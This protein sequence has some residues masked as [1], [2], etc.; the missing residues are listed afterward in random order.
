MIGSPHD[1]CR[2]F[3]QSA[4]AAYYKALGEK[5]IIKQHIVLLSAHGVMA[6]IVVSVIADNN[7]LCPD[8]VFRKTVVPY[9]F[10]ITVFGSGIFDIR[11]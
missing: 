11:E 3:S 8:N 2:S 9:S 4:V 5:R 6:V 1:E 10:G 7:V